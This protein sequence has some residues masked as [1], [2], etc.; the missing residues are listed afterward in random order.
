ML[1]GTAGGLSPPADITCGLGPG[2]PQ[3]CEPAIA[4]ERVATHVPCTASGQQNDASRPPGCV[5]LE[6]TVPR[7]PERAQ[8]R[9]FVARAPS[10]RTDFI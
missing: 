6:R 3:D 4:A 10:V 7:L 8:H 9:V 2:W 5:P 1:E